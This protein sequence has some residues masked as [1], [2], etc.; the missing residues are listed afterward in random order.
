MQFF[1]EMEMNSPCHT[2]QHFNYVLEDWASKKAIIFIL[3]V[4]KCKPPT[5]CEKV[6][7]FIISLLQ[8]PEGGGKT[9]RRVL[10]CVCE[11]LQQESRNELSCT[12]LMVSSRGRLRKP[13]VAS[14]DVSSGG[15]P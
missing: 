14:E 6:K 7:E 5:L 8:T 3:K 13:K 11:V 10:E 12:Y 9:P 1:I 2:T 15:I 4:K